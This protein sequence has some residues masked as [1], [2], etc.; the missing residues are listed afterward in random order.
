M[1][2][3]PEEIF[4]SYHVN[5]DG[6]PLSAD[7]YELLEEV[8]QG[9]FAKVFRARCPSR[10]DDRDAEVA[11]KVMKL[12]N[13]TTSMEEIQSEVRA[14]KMNRHANVLHLYC[15]FVVGSDLWL[16]L[17]LMD[18]GSCYHMLRSLRKAGKV[19]EGH[20]LPEE[21]IATLVREILQGLAY[22]HAQGQIHRDMKAGNVL[23]NH[24]GRVAIADFGVAGWVRESGE[25]TEQERKTF[26][27]TP[28]WMAPEVMEQRHGY[29]EKADIWSVGIT[30]LELAKGY[31]P[32]SKYEPMQ[33]L[34]K[35]IREPPPTIKSYVDPP[36]VTPPRFGD[37]FNAF[38]ARCLQK[39]PK[40]RP[41]AQ[42][43][44]S[45][46]FIVKKAFKVEKLVET[47]LDKIPVYA[48]P[49]PGSKEAVAAGAGA[50]AFAAQKSSSGGLVPGTTWV[51]PD[52][53]RAE[54][55]AIASAAGSN[56]ILNAISGSGVG[57]SGGNGN[58]GSGGQLNRMPSGSGP[59]NRGFHGMDSSALV[60]AEV[61]ED[62]D[63]EELDSI[64]AIEAAL[65]AMGGE[66]VVEEE[67]NR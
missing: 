23:M 55:S 41:S 45:D 59:S 51:F 31:A 1:S 38:V 11:I 54:L 27:G 10:G 15:C 33:V 18:R 65:Q 12:E 47:L 48:K 26:V 16:V 32:Y 13:I 62:P 3:A 29:N 52:E 67:E 34:I 39:D 20:G 2:S 49:A 25:R 63:D 30:T 43:L 19:P 17:P 37:K 36:G 64:E 46:P 7:G 6:W 61:E 35:T 40:M 5:E 60:E 4:A 9:A 57:S 14:M 24:K 44:L 8:G 53:V 28:C 22:I 42:E 66:G 21:V 50:A 56:N 58:G